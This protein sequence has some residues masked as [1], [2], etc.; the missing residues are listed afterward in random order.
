MYRIVRCM[1]DMI[2]K[3]F[4]NSIYLFL[5]YFNALLYLNK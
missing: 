1:A 4:S 5:S 3:I 2:A